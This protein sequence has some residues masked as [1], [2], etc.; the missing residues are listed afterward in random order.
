[1]CLQ[2]NAGVRH[3]VSK[4]GIKYCAVWF[5]QGYVSR[6]ENEEGKWS[7]KALLFLEK[8]PKDPYPS[9]THSDI[10]NESPS[11]ISEAFSKLLLLCCISMGLF[12]V[13]PL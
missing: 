12:V 6:L 3:A 1:M 10:S 5:L 9:S 13:L 7:L 8:F 4:L 11:C 2:K